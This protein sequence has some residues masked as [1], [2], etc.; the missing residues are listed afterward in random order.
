MDQEQEPQ[1]RVV[2]IAGDPRSVSRAIEDHGLEVVCSDV[3]MLVRERT[4]ELGVLKTLGYSNLSV[5]VLVLTEA[6]L[7]SVLGGGVGLALGFFLINTGGDPTGGYLAVF[8]F[9]LSDLL[10]GIGF[11]LALGVLSGSVP[12]VQAMRLSIV[13]ALRKV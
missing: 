12:A 10:R 8:H 2:T 7:L 3:E 6:L 5:L 9:P 13:D 1:R 4:S 11:V